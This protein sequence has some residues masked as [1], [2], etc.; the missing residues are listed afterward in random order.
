[1]NNWTSD[2]APLLKGLAV[3]VELTVCAGALAIPLGLLAGYARRSRNRFVRVPAACYVEVFRGTSTLVQLFWFYYVLPLFGL[4]LPAVAVGIAVLALNAG[5]Y[6]AEIVRGAIA[7]VPRE[8]YEAATAL[9]MTRSQMMWRIIVPQAVPAMLP[10]TGN[11][12]IELLKNT[13]LVSL[14]T[15]NELTSNAQILRAESLRTTELFCIILV[16]Y[17]AMAT[18]ISTGMRRVEWSF[19][20][21]R[22]GA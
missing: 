4:S 17:Y 16:M 21:S 13:A 11:L 14:I 22:R 2:L 19:A 6:G 15:I 8:Q 3:T 20:R 9:N 10:P 5:A 1:M 18:L 7:A 12:L